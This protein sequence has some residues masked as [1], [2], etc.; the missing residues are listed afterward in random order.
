MVAISVIYFL[1]D[2]KQDIDF[3]FPWFFHLLRHKNGN[4]R[5]SA[6][7]MLCHEIGPLTVHLRVP[8]ERSSNISTKKADQIL[9]DL[10]DGLHMLSREFY[11]SKYKKYKYIDSLPSSQYK[12]IQLVLARMIDDCGEDYIKR[13][14]RL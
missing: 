14:S 6:V 9:F 1:R 10:F 3:L 4:I 7:R 8:G 5:Q 2:D 13:M 12:S 11:Q